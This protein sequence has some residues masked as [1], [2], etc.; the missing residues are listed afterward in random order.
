MTKVIA[1]I[2]TLL[3]C[4]EYSAQSDSTSAERQKLNLI[5]LYKDNKPIETTIILK[6]V[7][8]SITLE[9]KSDKHGVIDTLIPT[10]NIYVIH[11]IQETKE[12]IIEEV[13]VE[14]KENKL[15]T[16]IELVLTYFIKDKDLSFVPQL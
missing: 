5:F 13:V 1:L 14:K 4:S 15:L 3:F 11:L 12:E 8:D 7:S 6:S 2:I 9:L 16:I 10:N